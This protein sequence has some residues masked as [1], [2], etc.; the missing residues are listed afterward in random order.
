MPSMKK[1][2]F[3]KLFPHLFAVLI[4]AI[5]T[6]V[7]FYPILEGYKIKQGDIGKHKAMS[8]EKRSYE[9]I[10][11]DPAL[12]SGNMFGGMP[13]YL[14]SSIRYDNSYIPV[15]NQM[16]RLGLPIPAGTLF[17]YLLGLMHKMKQ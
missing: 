3:K 15:L 2:D 16:M 17:A 4:F 8:H 5:I 7:Y 13:T 6:L 14:T 9:E 10:H 11:D 1:L 12:W